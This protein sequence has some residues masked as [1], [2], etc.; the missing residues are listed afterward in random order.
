MNE[1]EHDSLVGA[2]AELL[3]DWL[4]THP[5]RRPAGLRSTPEPGLVKRTQAQEQP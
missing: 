3:A 5:E 2:L 4:T 1:E